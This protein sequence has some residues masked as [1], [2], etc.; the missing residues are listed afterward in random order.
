MLLP[1][2]LA[3]PPPNSHSAFPC[4]PA[5]LCLLCFPFHWV[6]SWQ[7]IYTISTH[8]RVFIG[9]FVSGVGVSASVWL[10]FLLGK[11]SLVPLHEFFFVWPLLSVLQFWNFNLLCLFEYLI[12]CLNR[13]LLNKKYV[14]LL[15]PVL[16]VNSWIERSPVRVR[17]ALQRARAR[18]P[19]TQIHAQCTE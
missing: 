9:S 13:S 12:M 6:E 16:P 5:H 1:T 14:S 7:M 8:T 3:P 4:K 10:P 17:Q 2:S 19:T 15:R 18:R 11:G